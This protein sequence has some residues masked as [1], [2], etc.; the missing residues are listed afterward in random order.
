MHK[1]DTRLVSCQMDHKIVFTL[2][3]VLLGSLIYAYIT[4]FRGLFSACLY[5][6]HKQYTRHHFSVLSGAHRP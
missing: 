6:M 2:T 5:S 3:L 4:Y 1:E